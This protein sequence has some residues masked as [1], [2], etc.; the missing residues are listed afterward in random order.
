MIGRHV[1]WQPFVCRIGDFPAAVQW[2]ERAMEVAGD[3]LSEAARTEYE[4]RP[5]LHKSGQPYRQ[6]EPLLER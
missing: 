5:Q 1:R 6:S 2:E 3:S 4:S